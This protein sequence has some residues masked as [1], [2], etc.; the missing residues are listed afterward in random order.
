MSGCYG[1][2]KPS[3]INTPAP[4]F[5][6][7]DADHS[8]TLS[9]LRGK[10]VVLN[11]WATWC[12]P[13]VEEMPS[14]VQMQK[15]MQDRGI[16]VLAAGGLVAGDKAPS[17][18]ITTD[19]GDTLTSASLKGTPYVVYFYPKDDTSGCTKEACDF[20]DA[21][22]R[23]GKID[24]EVIGVSPDSIEVGT[25]PSRKSVVLPSPPAACA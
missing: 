6:I 25:M 15:K 24:A 12:P 22:P 16:M 1:R 14:L 8:V 13:C 20:R 7:Q 21:F 10:I 23:F 3:S 2:S 17:F 9:Q 4:D 11:F 19:S 18:K 5:T